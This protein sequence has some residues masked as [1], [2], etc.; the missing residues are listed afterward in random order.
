M[1]MATAFAILALAV[2]LPGDDAHGKSPD[3]AA[4]TWRYVVPPPGDPFEHAPFRALVLVREKPEELIE[5]VA[6]RGD[7]ARRR[8][9]RVRFGSASSTRVTIVVDVIGSGEVDLYADTD[10]NLK[11]D[12]RDR[13]TAAPS[14]AGPHCERIWRLPLSVALVE[15]DAVRTVPRA[16]VLRLGASGQ[17][18]GYAAA[19]YLEG[20]ITIG[21]DEKNNNRPPRPVAVRRV[22]GDG[23]G[24]LADAQDR[25]W[26]DVNR[27]G[28]F[29]P[30]SEQFLF[31]SVLNLE[32][33]RYVVL[34]DELGARMAVEPLA[35][36]GV[37]RLA[38]KRNG[39]SSAIQAVESH[40][41]AISRDGSVFGLTGNEPATVPAGEYRLGT[42]TVSLDDPKTG[43]RWSFVFSDGGAKAQ[44]R[45]YKVE[46]DSV[47]TIDPIGTPILELMLRD[48]T[49]SARPG[50]EVAVQPALY[51]GDGLVIVVAYCGNPVS[52]AI[53][54]ILGA[55]IALLTA[56]G[57]TL[58]TAHSGFS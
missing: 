27:D 55:R 56:D 25:I 15:K 8:Y 12:D 11:I 53:Q 57:T 4:P 18:L 6:Y 30:G 42:V 50:E 40:A 28:R 10:R 34:S 26:I 49:S 51:T 2:V 43:Q 45:W 41:T 48:K 19:G 21:G 24:L 1:M 38:N 35:G 5:S 46:K 39:P 36:T 31:S 16:V 58:A 14:A 29:D 32:G 20:K 37:F 17:T 54:E 47:V 3:A 9:A 44:P 22:D 13:A 52:P 33:A 7:P 23:N